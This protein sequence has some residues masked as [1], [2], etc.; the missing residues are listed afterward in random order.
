[1]VL[2]PLDVAADHSVTAADL[3]I[4]IGRDFVITVEENCHDRIRV[5]LS[6]IQSQFPS[7]RP[8]QLFHKI[9]DGI[10]DDYFP[11]LDHFDN[12]I[13]ELED[14]VLNNASP[15]VLSAS[16]DAK[17]SL[18]Q[19]R[20]VLVPTRDALARLQRANHPFIDPEM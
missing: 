10:V 17:R 13:D 12:A 19:V 2:K 5:L 15:K 14:S 4:F 11:I 7:I 3:D 9:L 1:V 16:F 18:I 8:D 20:R 6:Q